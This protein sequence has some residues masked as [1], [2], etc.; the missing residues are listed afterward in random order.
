MTP[1]NYD[2][3]I[4]ANLQAAFELGKTELAARLEA[5]YAAGTLAFRAFGTT[6][7][8]DRSGV[9]LQGAVDRGARGVIISLLARHAQREACIAE[10]W[11]AFRELPDSMPYVGAFR[12]HAE[13]PLVTHVEALVAAAAETAVRLGGGVAARPVSG[14]CGLTLEPLPKIRLCYLL[15]RPDEDFPANATCLF[16]ANADRFLPTDAL[17]DVGEYT[18]RAMIDALA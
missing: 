8:V 16:S 3:I 9:R 7:H 6:C 11:R 1:S 15:Y 12:A 10:P 18:T 13:L 5:E 14:D 2:A 17:A 4:Q